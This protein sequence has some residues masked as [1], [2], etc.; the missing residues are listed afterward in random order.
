MKQHKKVILALLLCLCLLAPQR[1][2]AAA[3]ADQRMDTI[4][5]I[6]QQ[7]LE[8]S[9][10]ES[11]KGYCGAC[12][13]Y[14]LRALGI[15]SYFVNIHGKDQFDFYCHMHYASGGNPIKAYSVADYSLRSA[16]EAATENGAR[17][18]RYVLVCFQSGANS[19]AA[20][21]GHTLLI[22]EIENGTVY[23]VDSTPRLVSGAR[24]EEGTP[25]ACSLD[26]FCETYASYTFEGLI[27]F[28][29][30][31]VWSGWNGRDDTYYIADSRDWEGFL[32]HAADNPTISAVLTRDVVLEDGTS[33]V[34]SEEAPFSGSF[35]GGGHTLQIRMSGSA[36]A[37]FAWVDGCRIR[38]LKLAGTV[39]GSGHASGLIGH[40]G[41]ETVTVKGVWM[42][43]D[44]S[45]S[46]RVS[47][48]VG[49]SGG[50]IRFE[51]C[52]VTG[53]VTASDGFAGAFAGWPSCSGLIFSSC[54][55]APRAVSPEPGPSEETL[56][57]IQFSNCYY[58]SDCRGAEAMGKGLE[59]AVLSCG[60]A[61]RILNGGR[62]E[63]ARGAWGQ[64]IGTHANPIPGGEPV[65]RVNFMD[66]GGRELAVS[67]VN[68]GVYD[69]A[70]LSGLG[71]GKTYTIVGGGSDTGMV[72]IDMDIDVFVFDGE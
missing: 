32:Q 47:G 9:H 11:L 53:S 29:P 23:F 40:S 2:S 57:D 31:Q 72:I 17:A 70:A 1:I 62:E 49:E 69:L 34:G 68:G 61:A 52:L 20:D 45:G 22:H 41:K 21:F 71:D 39:S 18:V 54:L 10:L 30:N 36:C 16:L 6:Y 43:A 13:G 14:Q 46:G 58:A 26:A 48:M 37:P 67:Y 51:D 12:V 35:D 64:T 44:V 3:E 24:Y 59:S 63:L 66:G 19:S 60:Q 33:G 55:S 50:M 42:D 5:D 38:D 25:I 56:S 7:A 15:N 28:D 4:A 65:Y 27:V 8:L